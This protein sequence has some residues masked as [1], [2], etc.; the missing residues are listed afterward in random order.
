[1]VFKQ[2]PEASEELNMRIS[3]EECFREREQHV[4]KNE[5]GKFSFVPMEQEQQ[6]VIVTGTECL[7]KL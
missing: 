3:G 5:C 1:M 6:V 4:Q 7:G 2:I